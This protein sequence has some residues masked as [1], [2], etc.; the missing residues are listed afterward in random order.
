[1]LSAIELATKLRENGCKVTPQRL[2]IYDMLS[3]TTEHPT[4]ETIYNKLKP[5]YPAMSLATVYKSVEVL[6]KI[7]AIQV[8]NTGE[9]SFRYDADTSDHQH[10]QCSCCGRVDDLNVDS[11]SFQKAVEES[12]NYQVQGNELYFYGICPSCLAKKKS[13]QH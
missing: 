13:A 6:E 2:A 10:I 4:A 8:L 3:K 11:S 5:L 1:M 12:S 7:D 9:D